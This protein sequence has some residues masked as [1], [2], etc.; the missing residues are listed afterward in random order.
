MQARTV[1]LA[2]AAGFAGFLV[3]GVAATEAVSGWIEFSV[4]VGIPAGF[5]AGAAAA[6]V[7]FLRLEDPAPGRRRPAI[8]V[9]G[10]GVGFVLALLLAAGVLRLRNSVAIPVAGVAGLLVPVVA[11]LR[12]R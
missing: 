3:V 2:L 10:F 12:E 6:A 9:A 1:G 7:V 4:F 11:V 8:A 5:V